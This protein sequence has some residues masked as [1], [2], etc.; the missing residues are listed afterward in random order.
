MCLGCISRK[1]NYR[2]LSLKD[3]SKPKSLSLDGLL[4]N[5]PRS[6]YVVKVFWSYYQ[7]I[8]KSLSRFHFKRFRKSIWNRTIWYFRRA[9]SLWVPSAILYSL[10]KTSYLRPTQ[11]PNCMKFW[12]LFRINNKSKFFSGSYIPLD[13]K[14]IN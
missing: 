14:P 7:V 12:F 6:I 5:R 10:S 11:T 8:I 2:L 3:K 4:T 1:M 9:V 13:Y